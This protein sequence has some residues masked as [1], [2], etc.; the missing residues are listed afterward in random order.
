MKNK[1]IVDFKTAQNLK[2]L[3]YGFGDTNPEYFYA[4]NVN[5]HK[6]LD[7]EEKFVVVHRTKPFE[8]FHSG[9]WIET[10]GE[11]YEKKL[12]DLTIP[13]PLWQQAEEWL[14]VKYRI[15]VSPVKEEGWW[16]CDA[17]KK[18]E[19]YC[20]ITPAQ[21]CKTPQKAREC[22]IGHIAHKLTSKA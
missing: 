19:L 4:P 20:F 18:D 3:G 14:Y 7:T 21:R 12:L 15:V 5:L 8:G 1:N 22:I 10:W 16:Y 9:K 17:R 2:E 11:A 13:A 6:P